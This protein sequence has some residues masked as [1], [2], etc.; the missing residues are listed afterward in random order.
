MYIP[1]QTNTTIPYSIMK[2]KELAYITKY[3]A[4]STIVT[5]VAKAG[6]P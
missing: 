3:I 4:R 1:D 2:L 5:S 6:F